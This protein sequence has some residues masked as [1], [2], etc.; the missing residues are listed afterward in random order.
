MS[1][2]VKKNKIIVIIGPTASGKTSL[3]VDLAYKFKGE[4]ISADSRQVYKYMD[5]G[6]G[7]DLDE[8]NIKIKNQ[9]LKIKNV[10]IPYHL[11]D[12]VSPNTDFNLGKY[13]KKGE[14]ALSEILNKDKLP[15]IAGGSGLYAQALV[16][17]YDLGKVSPDLGL[18]KKLEKL[19]VEKLY[20]KLVQ[21]DSGV[22][23]K[24]NNSDSN[25]PRRLIRYIEIL[26]SGGKVFRGSKKDNEK[27]FL[28]ICLCPELE[29]LKKRIYKRLLD[30]LEKENMVEE[31]RGLHFNKKVSW[32][33]LKS[34]GLEYKYISQYL[35]GELNYEDMVAQLYSESFKFS[36]RQITWFKRWERQ[37]RKIYWTQNKK[38][39]LKR[40]KD[41]LNN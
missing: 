31:V 8:Y 10:K 6:T 39:T 29:E 19:S 12:V 18:R 5:I 17:G 33:R 37:G 3:A 26:K 13:Y 30:R 21:L 7:K 2:I 35:L 20:K 38:E 32:K 36:K 40:V 9:K 25:N 4:V 41:F 11:I 16:E 1:N 34:F 22:A 15:I 27:E 23:V 14:R 28:I 24:L